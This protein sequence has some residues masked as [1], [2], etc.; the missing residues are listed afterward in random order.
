[1]RWQLLVRP[2]KSDHTKDTWK[3]CHEM[4]V[5]H[6]LYAGENMFRRSKLYSWEVHAKKQ[7]TETTDH[8]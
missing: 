2:E 3:E 7:Y 4:T 1:M 5:P 8:I 6:W